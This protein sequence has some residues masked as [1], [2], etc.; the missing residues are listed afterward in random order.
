MACSRVNSAVTA[1]LIYGRTCSVQVQ[2]LRSPRLSVLSCYLYENTASL[3]IE[4]RLKITRH[5]TF[6]F[7]YAYQAIRNRPGLL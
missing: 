6:G 7:V 1:T 4:L 2:L 5:L 3:W